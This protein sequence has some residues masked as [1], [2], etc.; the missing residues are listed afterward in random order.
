MRYLSIDCPDRHSP[1][2]VMEHFGGASSVVMATF[3][4]NGMMEESAEWAASMYAKLLVDRW[5]DQFDYAS[6]YEWKDGEWTKRPSPR[7]REPW[8]PRIGSK[9]RSITGVRGIVVGVEVPPADSQ[10]RGWDVKVRWPDGEEV[11][12]F[13]EDLTFPGDKS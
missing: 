3:W 8:T 5:P 13:A 2:N 4:P 6:K 7:P 1:W 9:V 10:G 12:I 11:W